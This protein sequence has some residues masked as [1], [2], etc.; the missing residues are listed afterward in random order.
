LKNIDIQVDDED[1]ALILLC[2]LPSFFDNFINLMLYN[3]D[4]ISLADVKSALNSMELRTRLN[5]KGND[6][7]AEHLFVKG[8]SKNFSNSRGQS[9]ERDSDKGGRSQRLV[10]NKKSKGPILRLV[11]IG[12]KL[13]HF[14][15]MAMQIW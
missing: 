11:D 12:V 8:C 3:R 9:N 7:Q 2:S 4:T 10:I 6:H 13:G 14:R 5:R 15:D 1:K